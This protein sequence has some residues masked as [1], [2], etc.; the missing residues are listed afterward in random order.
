M[1]LFVKDNRKRKKETT[2]DKRYTHTY[3]QINKQINRILFVRANVFWCVNPMVS[4]PIKSSSINNM[5]IYVLRM[6]KQ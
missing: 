5:Y 6:K 1:F 2:K 4:L 3:A